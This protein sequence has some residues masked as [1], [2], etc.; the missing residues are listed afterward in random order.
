MAP[1]EAAKEGPWEALGVP[2]GSIGSPRDAQ[3]PCRDHQELL[4]NSLGE[5]GTPRDLPGTT[6]GVPRG[7]PRMPREPQ[8]PRKIHLSVYMVNWMI[9]AWFY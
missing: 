7:T 4:R 2:G 9:L 6:R 1:T 3:G 8:G 5:P